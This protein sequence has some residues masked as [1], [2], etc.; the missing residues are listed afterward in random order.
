[1]LKL[2]DDKEIKTFRDIVNYSLNVGKLDLIMK[3][4]YFFKSLLK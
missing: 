3:R 2:I 1:M 4:A